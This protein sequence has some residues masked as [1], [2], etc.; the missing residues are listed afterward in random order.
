MLYL[1]SRGYMYFATMLFSTWVLVGNV[2][3]HTNCLWKRDG[4][5]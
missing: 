2:G 1:G 3:D 5:R 4:P